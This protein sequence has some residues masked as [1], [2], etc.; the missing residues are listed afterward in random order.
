MK[1]LIKRIEESKPKW[2]P[3]SI[4]RVDVPSDAMEWGMYSSMAGAN[5]A[6][7]SLTKVMKNA[8]VSVGKNVT[9]YKTDAAN[10]KA[11]Y[12]IRQRVDK[13]RYKRDKYGAG[14]TEC[15]VVMLMTF[16]EYIKLYLDSWDF[17][18]TFDVLGG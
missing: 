18:E 10:A 13:A 17:E 3:P 6:A 11:L 5:T 4:D 8:L 7:K 15:R 12:K 1:E 2:T 9:P 16:E 14:D